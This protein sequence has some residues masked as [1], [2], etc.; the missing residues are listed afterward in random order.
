MK[1]EVFLDTNV[2]CY[3]YDSSESSKKDA[4]RK[5]VGEV[6]RGEVRGV[7]SNQILVESFNTL[8]KKLGVK[9]DEAGIITKAFI[10][11]KYCRKIDYTHNTVEKA[12]N[13]S[14][15][16][17]APFLDVLIAETMKENDVTDII[18]ENLKD[19]VRIPGI[20]VISLFGPI[21]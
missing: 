9:R 18:T 17:G 3:A 2:I 20:K 8:T 11:S 6:L 5:F 19:F 14:I 4:C 16:Y 13:G 7:I 1:D 10:A 21:L 12:L 15:R